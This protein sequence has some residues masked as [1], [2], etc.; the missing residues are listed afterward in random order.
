MNG[1]AT[2]MISTS[3]WK[4]TFGRRETLHMPPKKHECLPNPLER[5]LYTPAII[6]F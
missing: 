2:K 1:G 5:A 3:L 6:I 4:A